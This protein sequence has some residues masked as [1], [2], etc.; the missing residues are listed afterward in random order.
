MYKYD[1]S[2]SMG[3]TAKTKNREPNGA[4]IASLGFSTK[5][6]SQ[7]LLIVKTVESPDLASE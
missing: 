6:I 2:I 5:N 3:N 4:L 7:T 1:Q